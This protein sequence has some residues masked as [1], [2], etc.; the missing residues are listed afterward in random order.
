[1]AFVRHPSGKYFLGGSSN[2]LSVKRE[3]I[4]STNV[5]RT[6]RAVRSGLLVFRFAVGLVVD[7]IVDVFAPEV[8]QLLR[9]GL[10]AAPTTSA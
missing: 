3:T 5:C 8:A 7:G 9:A 10:A 1:M 2:V 6:G 4:S